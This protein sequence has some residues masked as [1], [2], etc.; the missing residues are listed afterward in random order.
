MSSNRLVIGVIVLTDRVFRLGVH[1]VP[2]AV[3]H[4]PVVPALGEVR[5]VDV[6]HPPAQLALVPGLHD[7]EHDGEQQD[8]P[9]AQNDGPRQVFDHLG[10]EHVPDH[11]ARAHAAVATAATLLLLLLL[12]AAVALEAVLGQRAPAGEAR[13]VTRTTHSLSLE[14]GPRRRQ[15]AGQVGGHKVH[16]LHVPV[17]VF[18]TVAHALVGHLE[19][20]RFA[21]CNWKGKEMLYLTGFDW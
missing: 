8:A 20:S 15:V 9:D 4:H 11:L 6:L 21:L 1:V 13:V 14:E 17:V 10:V 5:L 3:G 12:V 18:W 16:R 2:W 19:K 7:P